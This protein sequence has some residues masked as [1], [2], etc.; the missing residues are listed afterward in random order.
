MYY[1]FRCRTSSKS[2]LEADY[3]VTTGTIPSQQQEGRVIVVAV[4]TAKLPESVTVKAGLSWKYHTITCVKF[5]DPVKKQSV[6]Q[7]RDRLKGEVD[8]VTVTTLFLVN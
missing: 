1:L 7:E 8:E 2:G 5:S 3:Q 6:A 4:A